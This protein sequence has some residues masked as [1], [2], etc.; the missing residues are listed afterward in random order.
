MATTSGNSLSIFSLLEALQ[1]RIW[2]VALSTIVLTAGF[3]TYA[4][5]Q[6]DRYRAT[7][8]IAAAQ[9]TAPE[10]LK[11]V[12]PPPLNIEDHLWTVREVV[13]SDA[14]LQAAS[15]Q[16]KAYQS[17]QGQLSPQQLEEFKQAIGIKVDSE[18][19]F[20]LTYEAGDRSDAMNVTNA[21]AGLFVKKASANQEEKT[22]EAAT[23]IDDQL[24]AL[25]QN[26]EQK[27][28]QMHDYKTK[29]V[30]ALPDHV[31]DI[32]RGIE[33]TKQQIQDRETKISEEEAKKVSSQRELQ[34]LESKG[35]LEQPLVHEKTADETKLDELRIQLAEAQTKYTAQYPPVMA[36]K[37]Q[38]ADLERTVASQPKKGR[39]EPSAT[40]LRYSQLKSELEGIDQRE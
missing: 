21:I 40:Y 14:V 3:M 20:Q 33:S 35:V 24:N 22:T 34:D 19:S 10:Y 37:R 31:D 27:S 4:H 26:L 29:A 39:N 25:K 6:P 5:L 13:Y 1:R 12:T 36:L 17:A 30:N 8:V 38:I 15:K 28:K 9:T 32:Y 11:H 7:A 16:S 23:V 18:H 2:I